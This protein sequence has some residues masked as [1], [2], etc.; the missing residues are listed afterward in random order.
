MERYKKT[1]KTRIALFRIRHPSERHLICI[2]AIYGYQR[3]NSQCR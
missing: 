2:P 1:L 3:E